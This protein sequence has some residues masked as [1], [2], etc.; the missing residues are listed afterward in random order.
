MKFLKRFKIIE[1]VDKQT[2]FDAH[3][4]PAYLVPRKDNQ[5]SARVIIDYRKINNL[6]CNP[7]PLMPDSNDLIH[8]LRKYHLFT[9]TDFFFSILPYPCP[10][11][12]GT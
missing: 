11:N 4:S 8:K 5:H 7:Y 12:L 10:L 2:S 9:T 6:L 1:K 3:V